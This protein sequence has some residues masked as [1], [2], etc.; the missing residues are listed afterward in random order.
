MR[1]GF[2]M[3]PGYEELDLIGPSELAT[4]WKTYAGGTD[5]V[6]VA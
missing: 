3:Y 1:F 6:T 4:M 5:C 2:M